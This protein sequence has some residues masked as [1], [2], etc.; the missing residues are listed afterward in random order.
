MKPKT[1]TTTVTTGMTPAEAKKLQER[2]RTNDPGK[3]LGQLILMGA[4]LWLLGEAIAEQSGKPSRKKK[5]R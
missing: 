4:G 3:A 5:A 2:F 1:P